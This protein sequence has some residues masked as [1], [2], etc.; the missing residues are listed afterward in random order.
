MRQGNA[1]ILNHREESR[2]LRVFA[3]VSGTVKYMGEFEIA[4]DL[5]WYERDAPQ[6]GGGPERRVIVFRLRPKDAL[7]APGRN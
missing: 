6:T 2:A 7:R 4:T 5:A 3:G 1:A